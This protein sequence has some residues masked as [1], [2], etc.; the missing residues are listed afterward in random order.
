MAEF[1]LRDTFTRLLAYMGDEGAMDGYLNE[2]GTY[3]TP[4]RPSPLQPNQIWNIVQNVLFLLRDDQ[5]INPLIPADI[6]SRI[7]ALK[8]KFNKPSSA[9]E[10]GFLILTIEDFDI[11]EMHGGRRRRSTRRRST[12][13]RSTRKN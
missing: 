13:R 1:E 2:N 5:P 3:S 6:R 8:R 4:I 9:Y 11:Y 10:R 12:R 7:S